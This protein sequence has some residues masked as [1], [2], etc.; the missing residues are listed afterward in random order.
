M[1][2]TNRNAADGLPQIVWEKIGS[3]IRNINYGSITII[4]QDGRVIQIEI[5]EKIRLETLFTKSEAPQVMDNIKAEIKKTLDDLQYG[6]LVI[7]IKGGKMTQID[8]TEKKRLSQVE[9]I[10]GDGI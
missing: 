1:P 4:V 2:F 9:G 10:Y 7:L 5:N 3:A 6:Q 8:R